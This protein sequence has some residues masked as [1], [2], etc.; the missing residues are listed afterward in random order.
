[1]SGNYLVSYL[2]K[3]NHEK[4]L[5]NILSDAIVQ[6]DNFSLNYKMNIF[7]EIKTYLIYF[8]YKHF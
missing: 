1:M 3:L 5:E 6:E 8:F 2:D 7:K 4:L